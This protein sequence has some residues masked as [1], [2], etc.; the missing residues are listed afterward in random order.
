MG[1]SLPP[2]LRAKLEAE[3]DKTAVAKPATPQRIAFGIPRLPVQEA[4]VLPLPKSPKR[5]AYD[6]LVRNAPV[7]K[8]EILIPLKNELVKGSKELK[9]STNA[10]MHRATTPPEWLIEES[11]ADYFRKTGK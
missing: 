7:I 1:L 8:D 11:I 10:Y 9:D 3:P 2:D 5:M 4:R 6:A